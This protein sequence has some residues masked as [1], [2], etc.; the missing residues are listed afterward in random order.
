ML[1]EE[2]N[3]EDEIIKVVKE[4]KDTSKSNQNLITNNNSLNTNN[5]K[6]VEIIFL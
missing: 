1:K 5:L 6:I 3:K 4:E 2:I